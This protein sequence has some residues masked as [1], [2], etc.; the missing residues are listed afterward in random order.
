MKATLV[1]FGRSNADL[2][3]AINFTSS[4][5]ES[6]I[7][8]SFN[9]DNTSFNFFNKKAFYQ[10]L[11]ITIH[12]NATVKYNL[13]TDIG[14]IDFNSDSLATSII[15]QLDVKTNT[16]NINVDF[17]QSTYITTNFVKIISSIGS[18]SLISQEILVATSVTFNIT[19]TIGN[20][21][22]LISYNNVP[23]ANY[24]IIHNVQCTSGNIDLLYSFSNEVGLI[25]NATTNVGTIDIPGGGTSYQ[26]PDIGSKTA[27][28]EFDF[29]TTIGNIK[30]AFT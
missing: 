6:E 7:I 25:I 27:I 8:V 13:E 12:P 23:E 22:L 28:Y 2:S 14:L 30:A 24:S 29:L 17:G 9:S 26:S 10:N 15:K 5:V 18:I 16:G 3:D 1:V 11:Y 20:I 19:S 21:N 4:E